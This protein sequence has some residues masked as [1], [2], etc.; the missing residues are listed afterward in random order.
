M[1]PLY[2]Y[3]PAFKPVSRASMGDYLTTGTPVRQLS[4]S[5]HHFLR[6][7][8]AANKDIAPGVLGPTW[9]SLGIVPDFE[10]VVDLGRANL[11][12]GYHFGAR[13]S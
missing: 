6:P 7:L 10:G 4:L 1:D 9:I 12:V 5:G 2:M 3:L 11:I 13:L 8:G